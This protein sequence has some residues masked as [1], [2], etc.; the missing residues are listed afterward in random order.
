MSYNLV[1]NGENNQ[2]LYLDIENLSI[3]ILMSFG[4]NGL[5]GYD[6]PSKM[7]NTFT[8]FKSKSSTLSVYSYL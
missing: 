1:V 4:F 5:K 2:N 6:V 8:I 7:T 3:D